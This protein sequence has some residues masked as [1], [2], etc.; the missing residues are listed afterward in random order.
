MISFKTTLQESLNAT[1]ITFEIDGGVTTPEEAFGVELPQVQLDKGV[2]LSGR[3]PIWLFA[4][5]IHHYHPARWI[6][7][8]D[9]RIGYIVVQSHCKERCEGEILEVIDA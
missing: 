5:L 7:V 4:R 3:G 8:H 2:I 9:P 1:L 6:A